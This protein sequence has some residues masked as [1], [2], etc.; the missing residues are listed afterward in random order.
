MNHYIKQVQEITSS[1]GSRGKKS[2][3][4]SIYYSILHENIYHLSKSPALMILNNSETIIDSLIINYLINLFIEINSQPQES[5]QSENFKKFALPSL[6][7]IRIIK[8]NKMQEAIPIQ[9]LSLDINLTSGQPYI[10]A[11]IMESFGRWDISKSNYQDPTNI[12]LQA[13]SWN[14][15]LTLQKIP[16]SQ[17]LDTPS[18]LNLDQKPPPGIIR[19]ISLFGKK[20]KIS[21]KKIIPYPGTYTT[22]NTWQNSFEQI[23]AGGI[24]RQLKAKIV[25]QVLSGN[26]IPY[27]SKLNQWKELDQNYKQDKQR[28]H[29]EKNKKKKD[30][31][32]NIK[33][34]FKWKKETQTLKKKEKSNYNKY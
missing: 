23:V 33:L 20:K 25:S 22:F 31:N 11:S 15:Y 6:Q 3:I 2:E 13:L 27:N 30:L 24:L 18:I 14:S 4:P 17:L 9:D 32:K 12:Y 19:N 29:M 5:L 7:I 10:P 21:I 16:Y 8:Y 34:N 1:I 26:L 28:K